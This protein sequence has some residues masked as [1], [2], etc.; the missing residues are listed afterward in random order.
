MMA[1]I[2]VRQHARADL[3]P[4]L[5]K[6]HAI[7]RMFLRHAL[8]PTPE[9]RLVVAVICQA[10]VDARTGSRHEQR[11]ARRFLGGPDLDAWADLVGLPAAFVRDVAIRTH[12]L[13]ATGEREGEPA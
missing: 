10:L 9:K 8:G 7:E 11:T 12:Y 1:N 4:P 2:Q 13:P 5:V 6:I 3:P